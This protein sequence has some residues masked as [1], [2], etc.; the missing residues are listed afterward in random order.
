MT[1]PANITHELGLRELTAEE[2]GEVS[3]AATRFTRLDD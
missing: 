2:I 1:T 3:G